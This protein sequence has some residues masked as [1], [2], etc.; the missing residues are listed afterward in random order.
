[1]LHASRAGFYKWLKCRV[2][3]TVDKREKLVEEIKSIHKDSRGN[4]GSPRVHKELKKRGVHVNHKTVERAMRKN[5][6]SSKRKRKFKVI[7]TD[8]NHDLPIA[9]NILNREFNKDKPDQAWVSDIT[10]IGTEEGWLYLAVFIDLFSRKILGWSMSSRI[11]TNL[12]IDALRMAISRRGK[13][14]TPLVHSDR[15]S[16][17]ASDAFRKELK[18]RSCEQ[19]MSRK[20]NCWDNAV[21]ES[22]FG[23]LKTELVH[24]EN[25]RT[26]QEAKLMIF[27]YIETF[28]N[29]RRLHS[30]LN[31]MSPD[32]FE[33]KMQQQ[34]VA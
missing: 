9:K 26:H 29:K 11:D 14:V 25:F 4:Y 31:Y 27:D 18:F 1:M 32:E 16:Q 20:A 15:G 17:F 30:T 33:T 22:F 6:I 13:K 3:K 21:A 23:A 19:S 12:I 28:Y 2:S 5:G 34:Q 10:Y 8:S 7:T 24:H